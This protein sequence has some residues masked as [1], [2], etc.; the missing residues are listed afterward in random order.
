MLFRSVMRRIKTASNEKSIRIALSPKVSIFTR[1][2]I[3][4]PIQQ[5]IQSGEFSPL[6][7]EFQSTN[8]LNSRISFQ[9]FSAGSERIRINKSI[10]NKKNIMRHALRLLC[11]KPIKLN[12]EIM[13]TFTKKELNILNAARTKDIQNKNSIQKQRFIESCHNKCVNGKII[14][15]SVYFVII[16]R[17]ILA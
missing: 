13:Q 16:I 4:S 6:G 11:N 12:K 14:I 10:K 17:L 1:G 15:N 8:P 5:R 3:Y 9:R 7:N 2:S